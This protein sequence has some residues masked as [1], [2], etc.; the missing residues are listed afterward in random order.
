MSKKNYYYFTVLSNWIAGYDRYKQIYSKDLIKESTFPDK[1][2]LVDDDCSLIGFEK[3]YKLLNKLNILDNKIIRISVAVDNEPK[4]EQK[5]FSIQQNYIKVKKICFY[6]GGTKQE[7]SIEDITAMAYKLHNNKLYEYNELKPRS[8]SILPI[9]SACQA[10]CWFCF[11]ESSISIEKEKFIV[12]L[13]NLNNICKKGCA[14]GVKRFV[15]TG[16][17]EPTLLK[18]DILLKIIQIAKGYFP[19]VLMITNGHELSKLNDNDLLKKIQSLIN[20]GLTTLAISRH[21][22]DLS[23]NAN[24]MGLKIDSDRIF[25]C[26]KNNKL[27]IKLRLVCV[28]QKNGIM[29][30]ESISSYIDYS[31]SQGIDQICFKELYVSSTL[32]SLYSKNIE[33]K[34]SKERQVGLNTVINYLEKNEYKIIQTLPW[35]SPVYAKDIEIAC[36]TEPSVGWER[37]IGIARSWNI[38]ADGRVYASLEDLASE[39]NEDN[40]EF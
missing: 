11:S 18:E 27:N 4:P 10:K 28:L 17:G 12:D 15:I 24:I 20:A 37:S 22:Y 33:T 34:L 5:G 1:F 6:I 21:H 2:F 19:T 30:D 40:Y 29:D 16:G 39:L 31:K 3:A 38:M 36:Y 32:E 13:S 14:L 23:K 9:A 8:I 25:T 7:S 26:I 35:G